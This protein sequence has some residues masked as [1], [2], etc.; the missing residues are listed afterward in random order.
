MICYDTGKKKVTWFHLCFIT[1][2]PKVSKNI[3]SVSASGRSVA[4]GQQEW[5]LSLIFGRMFYLQ[6]LEIRP[7]QTFG[8]FSPPV[9]KNMR[10][11]Q[12]GSKFPHGIGS[13]WTFK[14]H[15]LSCH[16]LVRWLVVPFLTT[17]LTSLF[18]GSKRRSGNPMTHLAFHGGL[19]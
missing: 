17:H 11:S 12:I 9:C 15:N 19:G 5:F 4:L 10:L 8:G 14:K 7:M 13:G 3:T 1:S 2:S 6:N 18:L 16:H